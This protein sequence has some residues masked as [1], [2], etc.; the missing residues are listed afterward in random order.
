MEQKLQFFVA[1]LGRFGQS[2]A[3]TLDEL[4]YDVMAMDEDE[5]VVQD[6]SDRLGYVVCAD[7]TDEKNLQAIGAGNADVAVVGIGNIEGS[8]LAT[9]QL[10]DMGVKTL[11]VKAINELHGKMLEKIGA[12]KIIYS[13]KEMGIRVAHHLTTPGIVDYIEMNNNITILTI[14][15]PKDWI[16]KNL[17][18]IDARRRYNINVVAL[19]RGEQNSINPPPD[20]PLAEG[21]MVTILGENENVRNVTKELEIE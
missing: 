3:L 17:I 12:D 14:Q 18:Q 8:L 20:M 2:V 6:L 5:D 16:G 9:L 10:K 19:L 4:G 15:V 7:A 11:V 1:G 13:E 21:D